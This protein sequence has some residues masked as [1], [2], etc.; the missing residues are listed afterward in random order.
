MIIKTYKNKTMK[1]SNKWLIAV[2]IFISCL[3][4]ASYKTWGTDWV[5]LPVQILAQACFV[6][7]AIAAILKYDSV[8]TFEDNEEK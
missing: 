5:M 3:F 6:V 8:K 1:E 4:L 2:I 7:L